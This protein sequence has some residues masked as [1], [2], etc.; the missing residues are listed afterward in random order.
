MSR[1]SLQ[2]SRKSARKSP[3]KDP[4]PTLVPQDVM[5]KFLS[6]IDKKKNR[7][8]KI[9]AAGRFI[10]RHARKPYFG[11]LERV[12]KGLLRKPA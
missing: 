4:A 7:A 6:T 11:D 8:D 12:T 10:A 3:P 2:H 1:G 9:E 5:T